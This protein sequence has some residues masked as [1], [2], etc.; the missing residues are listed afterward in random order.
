MAG[1]FNKLFGIQDKPN[2][3]ESI[4]NPPTFSYA[5]G[6]TDAYT[7]QLQNL[8]DVFSRRADGTDQFDYL[9]YVF[10]PQETALNQYY[11]INTTPGDI[12]SRQSGALPQTLASLNKRGLLD[13]GTSGLIEGQLQADRA[14]K[15]AE[16]F[17]S[18]KASQRTDIDNA[19]NAQGQLSPQLFQAKN[20]QSQADYENAMNN[21]NAELQR[22]SLTAQ[23]RNTRNA[24][25][26]GALQQGAGMLMGAAGAGFG[27]GGGFNW[28]S[29]GQNLLG[30][31]NFGSNQQS[32]DQLLKGLFGQRPL[33]G[34]Y[35]PN[36]G[37][38]G[39][40]QPAAGLGNQT[41]YK[42]PGQPMNFG[43]GLGTY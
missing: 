8:F 23:S 10:G 26:T 19:L 20:L 5:P 34:T 16:L 39:S 14:N 3:G 13:T 18:A 36:Y 43:S 35:Q 33:Q 25:V 6:S 24:Q 42:K 17:G 4:P 37:F 1:F 21:Y 9:K 41:F 22:Q 31:A 11:G 38:N 28:G 32:V 12:Y 40:P 15:L 27:G 30:N 2:Y 29:A 7:Q